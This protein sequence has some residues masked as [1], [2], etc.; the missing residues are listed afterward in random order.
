MKILKNTLFEFF[1]S[2]LY[3]VVLFEDDFHRFVQGVLINMAI[4]GSVREK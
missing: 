2:F 3:R 4:N 1:F